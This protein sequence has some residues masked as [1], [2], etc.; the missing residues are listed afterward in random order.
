MFLDARKN[1]SQDQD[2]R[3]DDS[4]QLDMQGV[5]VESRLRGRSDHGQHVH[6]QDIACYSVSW[7]QPSMSTPQVCPWRAQSA[8]SP[9]IP[10]DCLCI[11]DPAKELGNVELRKTNEP[12]DE[13][14]Y[15]RD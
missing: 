15:V 4:P 8:F 12:L 1:T 11:V 3:D 10:V 5:L 13:N 14:E 6:L 2:T 9:M 7:C